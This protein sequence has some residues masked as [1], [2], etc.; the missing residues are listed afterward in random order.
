MA[1]NTLLDDVALGSLDV[2]LEV[3]VP[4][5]FN[6]SLLFLFLASSLHLLLNFERGN[7]E[8]SQ[9]RLAILILIGK[10]VELVFAEVMDDKRRKSIIFLLLNAHPRRHVEQ[11]SFAS[12]TQEQVLPI[13]VEG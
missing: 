10:T 8:V 4:D 13:S 11:M 2:P 12:V 3:V 1:L 6:G 5:A 7:L 9:L